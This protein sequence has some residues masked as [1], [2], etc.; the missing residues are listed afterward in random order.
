VPALDLIELEAWRVVALP[1]ALDAAARDEE[2][3][4]RVA[5][6]EALFLCDDCP[7]HIGLADPSAIVVSDDGWC[8]SWMSMLAFVSLCAHAI[9]YPIPTARPV[10]M[11]GLIAGVPAKV[12]LRDDDEDVLLF[13]QAAFAHELTAR[14]G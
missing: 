10:V 6:D 4:I 11:Q 5:N 13:V 8:G 3:M 14:L 9:D 7:D 2:A 12:W 1:A